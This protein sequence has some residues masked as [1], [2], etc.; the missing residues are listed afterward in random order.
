M[1]LI[2]CTVR[3]YY[4]K[5][6]LHGSYYYLYGSWL[7]FL[8][9]GRGW[10]WVTFSEYFKT[11]NSHPTSSVYL[12]SEKDNLVRYTSVRHSKEVNTQRYAYKPSLLQEH[13]GPVVTYWIF[14]DTRKH[15]D[16]PEHLSW[17]LDIFLYRCTHAADTNTFSL[18]PSISV[19][20]PSWRG[21][22]GEGGGGTCRRRRDRRP[23]CHTCHTAR[24]PPWSRT[25][26]S[27]AGHPRGSLQ[28]TAITSKT[29]GWGWIN[30]ALCVCLSVSLQ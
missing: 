22:C 11:Q 4:D 7:L 13:Q 29:L 6:V 25:G 16:K 18:S 27:S 9:L 1:D 14:V 28:H 2:I 24:P 5:K 19:S 15:R 21:R 30:W 12:L 10:Y 20:V 23:G 26:H 17:V 3:G 8:L